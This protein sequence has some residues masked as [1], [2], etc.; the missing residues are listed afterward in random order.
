M[1]GPDATPMS[2]DGANTR[3]AGVWAA[4]ESHGAD[5]Y[6]YLHRRCGDASLAEEITQDTFVAALEGDFVA[7]EPPLEWLYRVARNRMIDVLRRQRNYESKLRLV[8]GG[9]NSE[10]PGPDL[11]AVDRLRMERVLA[12]VSSLHR[13]VLMLRY[14]DDLTVRELARS[15]QRSE[16]AMEALLMRA[17]AAL[18]REFEATD[19]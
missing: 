1:V 17:R 11:G 12:K 13:S 3:N 18:R 8:S 5:V 19:V 10:T 6:R 7:P 14:V 15:F 4:F 9:L 2:S 16:R